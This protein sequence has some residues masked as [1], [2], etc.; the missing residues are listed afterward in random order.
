[1]S[2]IKKV[3]VLNQTES[4]YSLPNKKISGIARIEIFDG[5]S[6]L[7]L[8][9]INALSISSGQFMLFIVDQNKSVY[10]FELGL[11]PFAHS[12]VFD[13]APCIEKGF[14][15]GLCVVKDNLPLTV[16]FAK[17]DDSTVSLLEFKK[18]TAEKC[19]EFR[20]KSLKEP[21]LEK[22]KEPPK[23]LLKPTTPPTE[24]A[25]DSQPENYCCS[26]EYDDEAVATQNF[27]ALNDQIQDK[28]NLLKESGNARLRNE[29]AMFDEPCKEKTQK[30]EQT[31][32][33]VQDE[34]DFT[35]RA[36][37]SKRPPYYIK[38]KDELE[39]VLKKFP[40][41]KRLNAMFSDSR[42]VKINYSGEKYYVVGLVKE[43]GVE[44]YICYGVP[45]TYSLKPPKELDGVASFIPLS[46]FNLHGDG[47]WM[48]FQD[49]FNGS[50]IKLKKLDE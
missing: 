36:E 43:N 48:M 50:C 21:I 44:K 11:R 20:R 19:L 32:S 39:S 7:H 49:A 9:V 2:F 15:I 22:E 29:N 42:W 33:S 13:K 31:T 41:E 46:I 10:T 45:A 24:K 37:R 38:V 17:T 30:G 28:L 1:M 40:P 23:E 25:H 47:Y 16:A 18:I 5:V 12:K 14:A 6:E 35:F 27:Y 8:S 3:L 4:G 26:N 34:T